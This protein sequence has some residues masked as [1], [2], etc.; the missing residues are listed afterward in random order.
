MV[1]CAVYGCSNKPKIRT[2]EHIKYFRFPRDK[3]TCNK[4]IQACKRSDEVNTKFARVCSLHF[5]ETDYKLE[6]RIMKVRLQLSPKRTRPLYP[7]AVPSLQLPKA[8]SVTEKPASITRKIRA[9]KRNNKRLVREI[10]REC[11]PAIQENP[12]Q[13]KESLLYIRQQP[14][15][16]PTTPSTSEDGVPPGN[17]KG[18]PAN[19]TRKR[20]ILAQDVTQIQTEDQ[21]EQQSGP[22]TKRKGSKEKT[23]ESQREET[24]DKEVLVQPNTCTHKH[25]I[26]VD[27]SSKGWQVFGIPV[28]EENSDND[29]F[30]EELKGKIK[31]I[32]EIV[33]EEEVYC[34]EEFSCEKPDQGLKVKEND[35][36]NYVF[37]KVGI[38]DSD[39]SKKEDTTDGDLYVTVGIHDV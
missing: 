9:D 10:V 4:W 19:K 24:L 29:G 1:I 36:E 13:Q 34:D 22:R 18:R 26:H 16:E 15:A 6:Y 35:L 37:V 14:D 39:E 11:G 28:K 3:D 8:K 17:N 30:N 25:N 38:L 23:S 21:D 12:D 7:W 2:R 33:K 32:D 27:V 20:K 31:E 5:Q